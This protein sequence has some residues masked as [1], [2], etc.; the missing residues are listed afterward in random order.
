MR[1]KRLLCVIALSTLSAPLAAAD[2]FAVYRLAQEHDPTWATARANHRAGL[3]K[4][5][6]GLAQLLPTL[7]L[8]ASDYRVAQDTRTAVVDG[9]FRYD[10]T[11][12]SAVL[13]QPL[14]RKQNFAGYEQ[15]KAQVG[16]AEAE[17]DQARH[18]LILRVTGA[19]FDVLVAQ[20]RLEWA[21]AEKQAIAGQLR[22]AQRNYEVG[23]GSLVDVH[24]AQARLDLIAAEEIAAGND[25]EVKK[26][27]LR[28]LTR[29]PAG[30]LARLRTPLPLAA[31]EPADIEH[32]VQA[33]L[34]A[35]PRVRRSEHAVA[36]ADQDLEISR[37]GHHPT[38]D[39]SASHSYSDAG[40]SAFGTPIETTTHQVGLVFAVP[41][42]QGGATASRVRESQAKR[43]ASAQ[44]LEASR[45]QAA[46]QAREAYLAVASG[47]AR[48]NALEQALVSN[49]QALES[50]LL[51]YERGLR[52]GV[53][54]L[55][56][57]R[58]LF[59]TQRDA[60]QARY[61]YLLARLRLKSAAGTL[62]END[63][64]ALNGLLT[65]A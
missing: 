42:F 59:R 19:Y 15:G 51:G 60:S 50:T 27:A 8:S 6:Q 29:A 25:L 40:G 7:T 14:Y 2:L 57:Q 38:L 48:V 37:A 32:W 44:Q 24:A 31:P 41:L 58:E 64:R 30:A 3:E 10:S 34:A 54:V 65:G 4:G 35:N 12:Y 53:D 22:L 63:L 16:Q 17:L 23:Q 1:C 56:A 5:P 43:E 28:V 61:D 11:A 52:T 33:A 46:Q 18:D 9:R 21:L 36:I 20:D 45:R 62:D 39:L 49:R 55:N 26:E 13:T 47:L